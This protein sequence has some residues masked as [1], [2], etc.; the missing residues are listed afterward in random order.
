M[1][2]GC[3]K[4]CK[5]GGCSGSG[6]SGACGGGCSGACSS[7]T[8]GSASCSGGCSS[9]SG[10]SLCSTGC[11]TSCKNASCGSSCS[12]N[13]TGDS[14]KTTCRS[15]CV[16]A[17]CINTCSS[18]GCS[19][20]CSGACGNA[21]D[22]SN[23]SCGGSCTEAKCANTC[24]TEC[25]DTA[26][27]FGCGNACVGTCDNSCYSECSSEACKNKCQTSC[28]GSCKNDGCAWTCS[29]GCSNTCYD[30][31]GTS[32]INNCNDTC[33][34]ACKFGCESGCK[35]MT[36]KASTFKDK[37]FDLKPKAEPPHTL[38]EKFALNTDDYGPKAEGKEGYDP[39]FPNTPY[40]NDFATAHGALNDAPY[41]SEN[42]ERK[43]NGEFD[44]SGTI[45]KTPKAFEFGKESIL[46]KNEY[47][48]VPED[49]EYDE[50]ITYYTRSGSG[51]DGDPYVY[52]EYN[53]E[54]DP[55]ASKAD[56]F[57]AALGSRG[58]GTVRNITLYMLKR[59]YKERAM[60]TSGGTSSMTSTDAIPTDSGRTRNPDTFHESTGI[61]V[62]A[63]DG[64]VLIK[65]GTSETFVESN[66]YYIKGSDGKF[67]R[68][69]VSI[70]G[71]GGTWSDFNTYKN[72]GTLYKAGAV[73]TN[74]S[75]DDETSVYDGSVTPQS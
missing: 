15:T 59:E 62:V 57:Y 67:T 64:K 2:V 38:G 29:V 13:C 20:E 21:A 28:L 11:N 19:T 40:D 73:I 74:S 34:S 22:C 49:F 27:K 35:G 66:E 39:S 14:C 7:G 46:N 37:V 58:K 65:V 55:T 45:V 68:A 17:G 9:G 31:C 75:S 30:A 44:G 26:C 71:Y 50:G 24:S 54:N 1:T 36:T 47:V 3:G 5:G 70:A 42:H 18:N 4:Q 56:A 32:C 48:P 43:Y 33:V 63:M 6:S 12:A 69:P 52:T 10:S 53:Y 72:A 51:V 25:I 16:D 61:K 23:I 60:V 41:T 8:S